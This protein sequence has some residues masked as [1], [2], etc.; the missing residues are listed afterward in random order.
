ML[1]GIAFQ[2]VAIT[3]Y[4]ALATEF[5]WRYFT[6]RPVRSVTPAQHDGVN[7]RVPIAEKTHTHTSRTLSPQLKQMIFA[8]VFSTLCIFIRSVYRTIELA[9]G[10]TGRIITTQLY[11]SMFPLASGKHIIDW[12]IV[13]CARWCYDCA[14][15]VYPQHLPPWST[16][17]QENQCDQPIIGLSTS[18][19]VACVH[20]SSN[21]DLD[22]YTHYEAA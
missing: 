19:R 16:P 15:D 4:V 9:D 2:M 7:D 1:G 5:L 17:Q 10:W 13:R 6:D 22:T 20:L 14:C 12:S 8:L 18:P 11:F 3:L 21:N